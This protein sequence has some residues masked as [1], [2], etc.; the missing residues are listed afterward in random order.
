MRQQNKGFTLEEV[1]IIIAIICVLV[2]VVGPKVISKVSN[3]NTGE[4]AHN[5]SK[6]GESTV[7]EV[8]VREVSSSKKR[9]ELAKKR[10]EYTK[11]RLKTK[12]GEQQELAK[13]EA[14]TRRLEAQLKSS[15]P[16]E[17]DREVK[18][19]TREIRALTPKQ[20][21]SVSASNPSSR[22][23][24]NTQS[25]DQFVLSVLGLIVA[26]FFER[27]FEKLFKNRGYALLTVCLC[28]ALVAFF[29]ANYFL[30]GSI[31]GGGFIGGAVSGG[32]GS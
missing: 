18:E 14:E 4:A 13:I 3:V 17:V 16:K 28:G 20:T 8:T 27:I 15:S 31:M 29:T 22:A 6:V 26:F 9:L 23:Q 11:K 25:R 24:G 32:E 19:A 5:L 7:R 10:L 1:M 12:R 2:F 30:M 21:R